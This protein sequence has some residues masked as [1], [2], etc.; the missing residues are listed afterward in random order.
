[1]LQ[2]ACRGL[3]P[4][5]P[6]LCVPSGAR[7]PPRMVGGPIAAASANF[8][9]RGCSRGAAAKPL[10][11]PPPPRRPTHRLSS[12]AAG[13]HG[14]ATLAHQ[15][16]GHGQQWAGPAGAGSLGDGVLVASG[17]RCRTSGGCSLAW[18]F[19]TMCSLCRPRPA[20][21]C[22]HLDKN[23]QVAA[24][25]RPDDKLRTEQFEAQVGA[26][27]SMATARVITPGWLPLCLVLQSDAS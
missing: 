14:G 2:P 15:G 20:L 1:M 4:R 23:L 3:A 9:V 19:S 11:L 21:I 24:F 18:R 13:L 22:C 5:P 10:T 27:Q 12:A 26:G 16:G 7:R 6:A 8:Q 17:R 25:P